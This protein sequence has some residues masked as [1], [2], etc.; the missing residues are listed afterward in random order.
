MATPAMLKKPEINAAAAAMQKNQKKK[1][2]A[3]DNIDEP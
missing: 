1:A 3:A 2:Q